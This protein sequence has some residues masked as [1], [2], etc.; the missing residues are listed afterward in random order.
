MSSGVS[1]AVSKSGTRRWQRA[2]RWGLAG[3]VAVALMASLLVDASTSAAADSGHAFVTRPDLRPPEVELSMS[4]QD[5]RPG[6]IFL[7]PFFP[8]PAGPDTKVQAGPLIV[9]D[10]GEPVWF[11]PDD[12][13]VVSFDFKVQEYRGAPVLTWWNGEVIVPPGYGNGEFVIMDKSYRQIATV[14]AGNGLQADMHDLVITPEDTALLLSY[15][16]VQHDLTAVGGSANAPV[17]EGVVQ[18]VDIGTG[19][20]L[21]EWHSL[22][23]IGVEESLQPLPEDAEEP[24]DYFHI[25][26]VEPDGDDDLLISARHTHAVYQISRSDGAVNWK[27]NGTDSDFEMGEGTAFE[28]QHDARR[29]A[30]G[31]I[32][33]LDNADGDMGK[34]RTRGIALRVDEEAG[35]AELIREDGRPEA[36]LS[37]NMANYQTLDDGSTFVGWGGADGFTEFG[38]DGSVQ[39]DGTLQDEMASYRA[40]RSPWVGTPLT[41]PAVAREPGEN[42]GTIVYASWNGA[43][44]VTDWRVLAGPDHQG[45]APVQEAPRTGFETRIEVLTEEPHVAV[46]ALDESGEVLG[47]SSTA[48]VSE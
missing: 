20:V 44:E 14:H 42:E 15:H 16:E 29:Q 17:L 4:A 28:W 37:P 6:H 26:S 47:T 33:I 30:D 25:N 35:T 12:P 36:I 11:A 38:P 9:D 1:A 32:T 18:E 21:F 7:G 3:G 34:D 41:D 13:G 19:E 27:L 10:Q 2:L 31:T 8:E 45:L 39:L 22:D 24:W 5:T 40:F 23:H 48:Q 46:E 43:T